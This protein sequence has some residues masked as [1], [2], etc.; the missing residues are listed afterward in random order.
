MPSR[1]GYVTE[2]ARIAHGTPVFAS[3]GLQPWAHVESE[4]P[5]LVQYR[6]ADEWAR[7]LKAPNLAPDCKQ[8]P[9]CTDEEP[10]LE[11]AWVKTSSLKRIVETSRD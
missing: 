7:I 6:P 2:D 10:V 4:E 1:P 9:R 11:H 8:A 3:A 5:F